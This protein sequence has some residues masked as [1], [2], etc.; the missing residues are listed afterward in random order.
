MWNAHKNSKAESN[1]T[2][3]H[4]SPTTNL[5]T[6]STH[7]VKSIEEGIVGTNNGNVQHQAPESSW[8]ERKRNFKVFA[9]AAI[10][11]VSM[12]AVAIALSTSKNQFSKEA[13]SSLIVGGTE[14][15]EDS[16]PYIVS[17]QDYLGGV[18]HFCGGSLIAKDVVITAAHCNDKTF[19]K[20][21]VVVGRHATYHFDGEMIGIKSRL[22]HPSYNKTSNDADFMLVFLDNAYTANNVELITLN[23]DS[24]FP[25][26][27]QEVTV[28]G[29]G[30]TDTFDF[31]AND[32]LLSVFLN[33]IS[34]EEC[35]ASEGYDSFGE[36]ESYH[37]NITQY[38]LCAKGTGKD[39]CRGDSGGPLVVKGGNGGADVLVGVVSQG[40]ECALEDF[41]GIYSRV[42]TVYDWIQD[43]VCKGSPH[44]FEA[45][46]D[47]SSI[48]VSSSNIVANSPSHSPTE[49]G[50]QFVDPIA[51]ADSSINLF[52]TYAPSPGSTPVAGGIARRPCFTQEECFNRYQELNALGQFNYYYS[53]DFG[54]NYGCFSKGGNM[55]WGEGGTDDQLFNYDFEGEKQSVLCYCEEGDGC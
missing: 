18:G 37:D 52:P 11:V 40:I 53:G 4:S 34:D 38:T 26:V 36:Y 12:V 16:F 55:Y 3:G 24:T 23:S 17:F 22:I 50:T 51:I 33:T 2:V 27:G 31:T 1:T 42:S 10:V 19:D 35:A 54:V 20:Y 8:W 6:M 49:G 7:N 28:S 39:A 5:S 13:K 25:R 30:I 29:W 9:A 48:A 47:C 43:E 45:G 44:A 41:P 32:Y 14:P 46:F 15:I 21:D